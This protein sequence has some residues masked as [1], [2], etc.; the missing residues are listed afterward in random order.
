LSKKQFLDWLRLSSDRLTCINIAL[1]HFYGPLDDRTKFIPFIIDKI[2]GNAAEINLTMGGQKR[3]FIYVD[4][5]VS[6]FG[7]ILQRIGQFT[8]G[9][10]NFEIGADTLMPIKEIVEQIKALAGNQVTKLNFGALPYRIN[11]VMEPKINTTAIR[12]LGWEPKVPL[13]KGLRRTIE[14]ELE[15]RNK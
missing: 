8:P 14:L 12:E 3:D 11:E 1:E 7:T 10:Y 9:F 4:D 13:T 15:A 6:A 2:V 5:V